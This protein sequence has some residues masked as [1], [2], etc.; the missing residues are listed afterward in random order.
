MTET[1]D[2]R[3]YGTSD[4]NPTGTAEDFNLCA[5]EVFPRPGELGAHHISRQCR[6]PRPKGKQLCK[7]HQRA[8]ANGV[9]V[10]IPDVEGP[11]L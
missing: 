3:R 1:M 11:G 7:A 9:Y 6:N 4:H 10:R 8:K 2:A 5:A